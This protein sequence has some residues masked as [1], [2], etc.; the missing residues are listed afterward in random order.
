MTILI[1]ACEKNSDLPKLKEWTQRCKVQQKRDFN[2][3][4]ARSDVW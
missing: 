2:V 3:G 1:D 4:L